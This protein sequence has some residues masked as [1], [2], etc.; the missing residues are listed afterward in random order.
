MGNADLRSIASITDAEMTDIEGA[1]V[2][3]D[4]PNWLY[5]YM[6]TTAQWTDNHEY[7]TDEGIE[8]P[9]LL[10]AIRGMPRFFENN[11]R[12]VFVFDG[13]AHS[14]K[15]DEL[16]ER[17]EVRENAAEAAEQAREEGNEI[18][19]ARME[20]RS[21]R[22]TATVIETTQTM[23]DHLDVPWITAPQAAESQAA[24]LGREGVVEY[25]ISEDYDSM[26]YG[27]PETVRGFTSSGSDIEVLS[28]SDTL[29]DHDLTWKQLVEVGLLCGT[30]YNDGVH[31]V[32]PATAL[33]GI[34]THGDIET[35]LDDR[36]ADLEHEA[37]RLRDIF[38]DP[39]VED[40]D[41][42]PRT[43]NPDLEATRK[44][45]TEEWE[46][47]ADSVSKAFERLEGAAE[48]TGLDQ[49]G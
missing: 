45:I 40:S 14:L 10:G 25:V 5:K 21:Q 13:M 37:S 12:P 4:A 24:Y 18:E 49:W 42:E 41:V 33:K 32:G 36:G 8:I 35:F 46:I 2:A 38:I 22:L 28:L 39:A 20:A 6:T 48:Q 34:D 29:D 31:G 26:L 43:P 19:A 17:R 23:L 47:P 3:V 11:L 15:A 44:F 9:H 7:T 1:T 16:D 30:D 27:A